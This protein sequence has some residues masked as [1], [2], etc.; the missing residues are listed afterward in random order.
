MQSLPDTEL[1]AHAAWQAGRNGEALRLFQRGANAGSVGC[2]LDLGYFYDVGIGT[3]SN[4][5]KAIYW[6]RQAYRMKDAAAASNIA[7]LYKEQSKNRLA[8]QWYKRSAE[9]GDGDSALELAKHYLS[10][11]GVS[12]SVSRAKKQLQTAM[13]SKL[14]TPASVAEARKLLRQ[15]TKQAGSNYSLKRTAAGRLR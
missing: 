4:K 13:S 12:R 1:K 5:A 10:G 14:V 9:L 3:R 15:V 7:V 8:F 2:M 11:Q 6:Y